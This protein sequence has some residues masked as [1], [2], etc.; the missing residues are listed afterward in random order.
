M[1]HAWVEV[2]LEGFGWM[3][4][5]ATPSYA[6]LMDP[7][8]F[9]GAEAGTVFDDEWIRQ[10]RENMFGGGWD[11]ELDDWEYDWYYWQQAGTMPTS[12]M[13]PNE[14]DPVSIGAHVGTVIRALLLM[15]L[16]GMVIVAF[17]RFMQLTYALIKV[18]RYEPDKKAITYFKGVLDL[19]IFN[20]VPM[21]PGET[22]K[23]FGTHTGKR[24]KFKGGSV[25][26]E[27]LIT[28]YY[29]AK[30]SPH[31]ITVSEGNLMEEA[32]FDMINFIREKNK[33][34]KVI[35]LRYVRGLGAI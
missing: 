3:I 14:T 31:T 27:D 1:A 15:V 10:M 4:V 13:P 7:A 18:R 24:F 12:P 2:Y 8:S 34:L 23:A 32:Y 17:A 29:K 21:R 22:P 9:L 35:Y 19:V 30:Y 6:F 26:F 5:E 20:T 11:P 28:L 16:A 33:P 25:Y